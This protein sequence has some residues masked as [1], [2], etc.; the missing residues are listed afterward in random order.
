[1]CVSQKVSKLPPPVNPQKPWHRPEGD[2]RP[3]YRVVSKPKYETVYDDN[4]EKKERGRTVEHRRVYFDERG[5]ENLLD[6][7]ARYP[8]LTRPNERNIWRLGSNFSVEKLVRDKWERVY[9]PPFQQSSE[10]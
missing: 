5:I 4:D 1:M 8:E 10:K 7:L 3:R 6:F 9:S 2:G